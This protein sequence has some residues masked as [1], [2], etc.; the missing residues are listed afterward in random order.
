MAKA[1]DGMAII[2][3]HIENASYSPVYLLGGEESYLVR[4]FCD[5]LIDAVA[6]RND[7]MNYM[8]YKGEAAVAENIREFAMT[9]PFFAERRVI[10]IENSGFFKKGNEVI[11]QLLEEIPSTTIIVFVEDEIDKRTK[12]YKQLAKVG[13]TADFST[14]DDKTLYAWITSLFKSEGI[15]VDANAVA[16]LIQSVGSNMNQL[17]NEVEKLKCY[18]MGKD[19]VTLSDVEALCVNEVESKIFDMMDYLSTRNVKKTMELYDDLLK[20]REPA[21][22]LLFLITRQYNILLKV[23]LALS[24]GRK[25]SE[26][27]SAVKVPPFTVKKYIAQCD[28]Y[29]YSQLVDAVNLCQ[30]TD[31]LIKSGAM[32]DNT[33]VE[34]LIVKLLEQL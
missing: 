1:E 23:K 17:A 20:L 29:T 6:D 19:K 4:Q 24:G 7:S 9:M 28:G 8:V 34:M 22:R 16:G 31:S 13:T 5:K 21:M 26:I 33:A 25:G 14:P 2:N 32:K 15:A 10:R 11:E 18:C 3:S 27:A 12:L 30:E